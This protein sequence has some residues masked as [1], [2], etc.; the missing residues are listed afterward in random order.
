LAV[1]IEGLAELADIDL[2]E[3]VDVIDVVERLNKAFPTG[4]SA[5]LCEELALTEKS[6]AALLRKARYRM[7]IHTEN[8]ELSAGEAVSKFLAGNNEIGHLVYEITGS[9]QRAEAV[10]ACG[11]AGN[12]KP[13]VLAEVLCSLVGAVLCPNTTEYTRMELIF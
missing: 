13:Q 6:A 4:I 9:G 5:L 12:L 8:G 7:I 2:I 3:Q 10:I 11:G 1:G